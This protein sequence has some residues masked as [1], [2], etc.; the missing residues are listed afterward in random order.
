MIINTPKKSTTDAKSYIDFT[1]NS[2]KKKKL[3]SWLNIEVDEFWDVALFL[4]QA[5]YAAIATDPNS[6]ESKNV[7]SWDISNYLPETLQSPFID[8]L[9][10]YTTYLHSSIY[11]SSTEENEKPDPNINAAISKETETRQQIAARKKILRDHLTPRLFNLVHDA[12]YSMTTVQETENSGTNSPALHFIQYVSR[13]LSLDTFISKDVCKLQK[14]LFKLAQIREFSKEAEFKNPSESYVLYDVMCQFCSSVSNLDLLRDIQLIDDWKCKHCRHDYDKIAVE[15]RLI[16][17][18]K[19]KSLAYQLQDFI[20]EKCN[21]V[22]EDNLSLYCK[23]CSGKFVSTMSED[24]IQSFI[25]RFG[26]IADLHHFSW[27]NDIV[28]WMGEC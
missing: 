28:Q 27:L 6:L 11:S 15:K 1:L 4:D 18:L 13:I 9:N 22:K 20:C 7:N 8:I 5:N 24:D 21:L 26:K 12:Q 16:D 23:N 14:N 2:I 25:S 10:D 19:R 3:Y 17:I